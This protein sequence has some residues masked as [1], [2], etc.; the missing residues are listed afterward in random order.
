MKKDFNM[1]S[2]FELREMKKF[3]PVLLYKQD[4]LELEKILLDSSMHRNDSIK[5][6][7]THKEKKY[8]TSSFQD[9]FQ[10]EGLPEQINKL[11]ISRN[12][13]IELNGENSINRGLDLTMHVNYVHCQIH[14][15][16]QDW[17]N[18]KLSRLGLFF[19]KRKPWYAILN[20][21]SFIFPTIAII[22][23][24]YGLN[25][26]KTKSLL[27][28]LPPLLLFVLMSIVS[29]LSVFEKIFPYVR[30][31]LRDRG[32]LKFGFNEFQL[33][34]VLIASILTI[35]QIIYNFSANKAP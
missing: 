22:C 28:S 29:V 14:S 1:P 24:F 18:G 7:L 8:T 2:E 6:S 20:K 26:F 17:Y 33:I 31:V 19:K 3:P 13:W 4:L 30:V 12:G 25:M 21:N 23:L 27:Y 11:S 34:V 9:L 35:V 10:I 5:I 32:K 16:D 15:Y